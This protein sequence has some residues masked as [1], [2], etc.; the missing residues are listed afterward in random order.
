MRLQTKI[1]LSI[2]PLILAAIMFLALWSAKVMTREVERNFYYQM[3]VAIKAYFHEQL[4]RRTTI[5]DK[6]GLLNVASFVDMY[7]RNA[8]EHAEK[9]LL[10]PDDTILVFNDEGKVLTTGFKEENAGPIY[11]V[12][13]QNFTGRYSG[14]RSIEQGT[15]EWNNRH[16]LYSVGYYRPWRWTVLYLRNIAELQ[17]KIRWIYT[18]HAFAAGIVVIAVNLVVLIVLRL[19]FLKPLMLIHE[20]TE[21]IGNT[22]EFDAIA[23]SS[24]DELGMLARQMEKMA[25][26]IYRYDDV[27]KKLQ[28]EA[29]DTKERL[30]LIIDSAN[31]GTWEWDISSGSLIL[32]D[33]WAQMA[34]YDLGELEQNIT[35]FENLVYPEDYQRLSNRL[36]EHVAGDKTLLRRNTG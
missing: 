5:L 29:M 27:Q 35:T 1:N 28:E 4:E 34:G 12:L 30:Q 21:L 26:R 14:D 19:F 15:V 32:N 23:F 16:M 31:L 11:R 20:A 18:V 17:E 7:K 25:G 24:K 8:L 36:S 13:E 2:M 6:N 3:E 22:G 10:D 9:H 33:R